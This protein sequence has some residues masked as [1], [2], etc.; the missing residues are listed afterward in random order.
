LPKVLRENR[1]SEIIICSEEIQEEALRRVE[2]IA[3]ESNVRLKRI[4]ILYEDYRPD[5]TKHAPK[6]ILVQHEE[7][8][9]ASKTNVPVGRR[10]D[11]WPQGVPMNINPSA[12]QT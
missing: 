1:I 10:V 4:R 9:N 12:P 5:E 7:E 8:A 6:P 3:K 2:E 11:R